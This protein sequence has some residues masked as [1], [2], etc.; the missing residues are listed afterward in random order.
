MKQL[1]S[2]TVSPGIGYEAAADLDLKLQPGMKVVIRCDHYQDF[3]TVKSVSK[4]APFED[5]EEMERQRNATF[6]GRHIEGVHIP[7]VLRVATHE[8]L[9]RHSENYHDSQLMMMEAKEA[10]QHHGLKMKLVG[11][12]LCFDRK[13]IFFQFSSEGRVDFRMLLRDLTQRFRMRV[14]LRQI[15]VRDEA[16]IIGG[17]GT[18]GRPYCCT[19]FLSGISSVNV[20]TAKQQGL[21][22]N[23]QNISG[24]CGRLRCCLQYEAESYRNAPKAVPKATS[25]RHGAANGERKAPN[26]ANHGKCRN[27]GNGNTPGN[28]KCQCN[29]HCRH[30]HH[31]RPAV[32]KEHLV[33]GEAPASVG[34]STPEA[35]A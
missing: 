28:C 17:I 25:V 18:C 20:K 29:S 31:K 10:I 13:T 34:N 4:N 27:N 1:Y 5:L 24:A 14:E 3:A 6:R 12:H 23:P 26:D 11:S 35:T 8:D 16:A 32:G 21:S 2:L 7:I 30:S 15:G 33:G 19:T 9:E 22:L